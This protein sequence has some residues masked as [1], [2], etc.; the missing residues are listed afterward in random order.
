[1]IREVVGI[2]DLIY[3]YT[4]KP[5]A[6]E[7]RRSD[8]RAMAG[9]M[10]NIGATSTSCRAA[11]G[12]RAARGGRRAALQVSCRGYTGKAVEH[13]G[14]L[15]AKPAEG[16]LTDVRAAEMA[17]ASLLAGPTEP[18]EVREAKK[19][20]LREMLAKSEAQRNMEI[21]EEPFKLHFVLKFV[22]TDKVLGVALNQA[23]KRGETPMSPYFF[24]PREDAWE[25]VQKVSAICF[26]TLTMLE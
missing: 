2:G 4:G 20:E 17:E 21:P 7:A 25:C 1:M 10:R 6:G 13:I 19:M 11:A 14:K 8:S 9:V 24:W 18:L 22:W 15:R 3:I 12:G 23:N 5:E 26:L 16:I